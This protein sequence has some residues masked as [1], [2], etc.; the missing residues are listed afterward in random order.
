LPGIRQSEREAD[1]CPSY[2]TEAYNA[3]KVFCT[4]HHAERDS[5]VQQ[6]DE[7]KKLKVLV[8]DQ[9]L[10]KVKLFTVLSCS[11]LIDFRH[12]KITSLF[13]VLSQVILP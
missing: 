2:N 12:H 10:S 8:A 1:H 9:Q 6:I 4:F 3:W 11:A 5:A 7:V 13:S